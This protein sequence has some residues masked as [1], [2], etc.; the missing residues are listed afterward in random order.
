MENTST[1]PLVANQ[2]K[3]SCCGGDFVVTIGDK[4][5]SHAELNGARYVH[6]NQLI[7]AQSTNS[8]ITAV[9]VGILTGVILDSAYY[10]VMFGGSTLL[11]SLITTMGTGALAP[12]FPV[13]AW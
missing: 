9:A 13:S 3:P 10:G 7:G 12:C 6:L 1:T 11:I 5:I 8:A 2:K 4:D